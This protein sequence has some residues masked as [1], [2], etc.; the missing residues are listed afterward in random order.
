[1]IAARQDVGLLWA[2]SRE[3]EA[4]LDEAGQLLQGMRHRQDLMMRAAADLVASTLRVGG[5]DSVAPSP[6]ASPRPPLRGAERGQQL[7][8]E[9]LQSLLPQTPRRRSRTP[10]AR[11]WRPAG[12][13]RAWEE[14]TLLVATGDSSGPLRNCRCSRPPSTSRTG[15][16]PGLPPP[17]RGQRGARI[18]EDPSAERVPQPLPPPR[19]PRRLAADP[20]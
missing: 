5:C 17:P 8:Q 9:E 4:V 16:P 19:A 20:G 3:L 18:A 10:P 14:Q 2:T 15:E 1:M 6:P 11:T 13:A 12:C 7:P